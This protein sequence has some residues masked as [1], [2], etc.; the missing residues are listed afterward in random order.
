M[1]T[2][3][4]KYNQCP[5]CQG[6]GLVVDNPECQYLLT[7]PH[8][9]RMHFSEVVKQLQKHNAKFSVRPVPSKYEYDL[10]AVFTTGAEYKKEPS[11][12]KKPKKC[13]TIK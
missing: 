5:T 6:L 8:R 3:L 13:N 1:E 10:Y 2:A 7:E 12:L 11:Y 9:D 4:K